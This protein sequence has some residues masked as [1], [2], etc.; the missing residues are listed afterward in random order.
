MRNEKHGFC[1][2]CHTCKRNAQ[3]HMVLKATEIHV[4]DLGESLLWY[5]WNLGTEF[6]MSRSIL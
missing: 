5:E 1:R 3:I 4:S 2:F 6:V